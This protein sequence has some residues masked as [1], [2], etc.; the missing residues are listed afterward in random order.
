M[1]PAELIRKLEEAHAKIKEAFVCIEEAREIYSELQKSGSWVEEEKASEAH[2]K[3]LSV[4]L[5]S[6]AHAANSA[7]LSA[8]ADEAEDE[9]YW[10][11]FDSVEDDWDDNDI[12]DDDWDDADWDDWDDSRHWY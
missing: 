6:A 3:S 9:E 11:D 10:N 12:D 4:D 2:M 5:M 8:E 7:V 1:D